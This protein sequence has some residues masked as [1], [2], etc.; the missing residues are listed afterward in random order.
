MFVDNTATQNTVPVEEKGQSYYAAVMQPGRS[1]SSLKLN[2]YFGWNSIAKD[3][4]HR[5]WNHSSVDTKR[6]VWID[7][8]TEMTDIDRTAVTGGGRL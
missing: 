5:A 4:M 3:G 2:G 7:Q 1:N 8:K 6:N